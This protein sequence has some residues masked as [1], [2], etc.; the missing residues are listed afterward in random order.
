M[1]NE[2]K[3]FLAVLQGVEAPTLTTLCQRTLDLLPVDGVSIAL[4]TGSD[5]QGLAGSSGSLR[6][7]S[8]GSRITLGQGP[9]WTHMRRVRA[10]SWRLRLTDGRWP[11][12]SPAALEL[13][14]RSVSA[15]PMK[16]GGIRLG[17]LYL[18]GDE[19]GSIGA[20]HLKR[21]YGDRADHPDRDRPA[22]SGQ[23]RGDRIQSRGVR[24]SGGRASGHR[25][26]LG[27]ARVQRVEE[28]LVRLHGHAFVADRPIDEIAEL[29]VD[30]SVRFHE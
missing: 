14:V 29:V 22:I 17:V 12:F 16:I 26:D 19:P 4:M 30:G 7:S 18:Y 1:N 8:S 21:S 3:R 28:A 5:H 27:S 15:L 9:G 24:L 23:F 25:D 13:G 6:V 11:L 10:S 2:A 20:E